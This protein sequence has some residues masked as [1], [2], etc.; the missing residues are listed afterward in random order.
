MLCIVTQRVDELKAA[1][2]ASVSM[3]SVP[4]ALEVLAKIVVQDACVLAG[5]FPDHPVYVRL[6]RREDF[7]CA[8]CCASLHG[9]L[10]VCTLQLPC[11]PIPEQPITSTRLMSSH[12][13][14][15]LSR[16][17]APKTWGAAAVT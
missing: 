16:R 2:K 11:S 13:S 1:G 17:Q 5:D 10:K 6:L 9:C 3:E 14:G 15:R 12:S 7:R 8:C 4:I